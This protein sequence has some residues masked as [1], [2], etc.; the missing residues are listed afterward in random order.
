M[1]KVLPGARRSSEVRQPPGPQDGRKPARM[2]QLIELAFL[3]LGA[4]M[5]LVALEADDEAFDLAGELVGVADGP[6]VAV[7]QGLEAMH[8]VAVEAFVAGLA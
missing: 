1:R 7:A 8:F 5:G 4:E 6:A 3:G 2:E